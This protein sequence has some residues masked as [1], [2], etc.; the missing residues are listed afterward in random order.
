MACSIQNLVVDTD[1]HST[2]RVGS[3]S[4]QVP[5]LANSKHGLKCAEFFSDGSAESADAAGPSGELGGDRAV[6]LFK[7]G[8]AFFTAEEVCP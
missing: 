2:D 3:I 8:S 5:T 7:F 1:F 6:F 4:V